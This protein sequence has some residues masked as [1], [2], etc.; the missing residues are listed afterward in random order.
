MVALFASACRKNNDT[1]K[2]DCST[3][4]APSPSSNSP[5]GAGS[6]ISLYAGSISNV[7]YYNWTGP[8]GYT[9]GSQNPTIPHASAAN[10]GTY[11]LTI[12]KVSGCVTPAGHVDIAIDTATCTP[13]TNTATVTGLPTLSFSSILPNHNGS[14]GNYRIT[15]NGS[16]GDLYLEFGTYAQPVAGVYT[17]YGIDHFT[18]E[19]NEATV[20]M[21]TNSANWSMGSGAHSKLFVTVT[22]GKVSATFCDVTMSNS[23]W[24]TSGSV[25][26]N[27]LEQ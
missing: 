14:S 21:N 5:V 9:S 27:V 2:E 13:V 25:S 24:W 15:A 6:T 3:L 19:T 23:T 17:L 4:T 12:T 11:S 7:V 18:I 20:M 8:N 22:G 10:A 16:N 1:P 26:A